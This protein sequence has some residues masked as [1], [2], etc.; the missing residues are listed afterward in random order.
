M[1]TC[2]PARVS[3]YSRAAAFVLSQAPRSVAAVFGLLA[4]TPEECE[5]WAVAAEGLEGGAHSGDHTQLAQQLASS[6]EERQA[7]LLAL[8]P[9]KPAAV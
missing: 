3:V 6:I 5:A 2:V 7:E 1:A 8:D 4:N 9:P